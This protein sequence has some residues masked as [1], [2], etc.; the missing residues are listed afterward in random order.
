[1]TVK[2]EWE[3]IDDGHKRAKVPGGYLVKSYEEVCSPIHGQDA[4]PEFG[5][6]WRVSMCFVPI[7]PRTGW[8]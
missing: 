1:M 4:K 7:D 5:Y 3:Q 6:E 2:L 8:K